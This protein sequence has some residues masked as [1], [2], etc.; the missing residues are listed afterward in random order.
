MT[1]TQQTPDLRPLLL[2]ALDVT[3]SL[4]TAAATGDLD[5]PTPCDEFDVRD[6]LDHLVMVVRR[7]RIVLGGGAF[8]DA[9]P[10]GAETGAELLAAWSE[11]LDALRQAL[12]GFD[13]GIEVTAPFG[14][15]SA[16]AAVPYYATELTVHDWDL[17]Q[18]VSRTDLLDPAVAE[19]LVEPTRQRVPRAGREQIPFGEVVDT[20]EDAPAYDR[21]VAWMGRDPHWRA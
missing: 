7:V 2:R 3:D 20:P 6:L 11:G 5:R 4:V 9:V 1:I 17:A 13:L 19:P 12:P 18:A 14:T 15:L 8:L 10:S 16:A 21:L